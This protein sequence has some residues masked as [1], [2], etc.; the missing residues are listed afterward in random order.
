MD[1]DNTQLYSVVVK[2]GSGRGSKKKIIDAGV[3]SQKMSQKFYKL[4]IIVPFFQKMF[5]KF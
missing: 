2:T 4:A 5:Q 1:T 3:N